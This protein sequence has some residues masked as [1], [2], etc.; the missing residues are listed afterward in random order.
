MPLCFQP[1]RRS[2]RDR[3]WVRYVIVAGSTHIR[4]ELQKRQ[5]SPTLAHVKT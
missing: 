4:D 1:P 5:T 2:A 3:P